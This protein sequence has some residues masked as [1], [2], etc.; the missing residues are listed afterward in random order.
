M[1]KE[2]LVLIGVIAFVAV[3]LAFAFFGNDA[4]YNEF[5]SNEQDD[6]CATP[7]GYTDQQWIEHMGHHPDRYAKCL[8]G[9]K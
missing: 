5:V 3:V 2:N 4:K 8:G 7:P 9:N 1:E 6:I